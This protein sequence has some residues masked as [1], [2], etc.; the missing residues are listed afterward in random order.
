M[1]TYVMVLIFISL[2][3][4]RSTGTVRAC[5]KLSLLKNR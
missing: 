4:K 5:I 3:S 2:H 1:A